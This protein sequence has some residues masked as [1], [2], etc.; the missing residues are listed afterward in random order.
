ML[1]RS[2][3]LPKGFVLA[4]P[5]AQEGYDESVIYELERQDR[6]I[7]ERK[8]DGWKMFAVVG[9]TGKV[10]FFTDGLNEIDSRLDH[11]KKELESLKLPSETV[12]VGEAISDLDNSDDL[13]KVISIFHSNTEKSIRFQK[14]NSKLKFMVFG[15]I[16][17]EGKPGM[18][19]DLTHKLISMTLVPPNALGPVPKYVFPVRILNMSFDEAKKLVVEKGWEGLVLYD[20]NYVLSYRLDGKNPKRPEGCYKWK[21][22]WEDDF[23]V[24]DKIMRSA[25]EG[26]K[27]LV[28][29]QIDPFTKKEFYCG[30]LGS[31]SGNMRYE[32]RFMSY[33]LVVQAKFEMRFPKSGKIRNA[34]FLRIRT[35]K[36]IHQCVAPKS[37]QEAEYLQKKVR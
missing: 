32:L 27:E 26:V 13:G 25:D 36:P 17:P 15:A 31:F 35:D 21:P 12:L 20:R 16:Y 28:L 37:Y 14:I 2:G 7:I 4:K 8:R 30:K 18:Q 9:S 10:R 24:R 6:L 34:R 3:K 29:L 5:I 23:V 33:P 11:I 19:Y 1:V 22:I